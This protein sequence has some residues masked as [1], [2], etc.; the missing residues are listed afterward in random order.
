VSAEERSL[1]EIRKALAGITRRLDALADAVGVA[2]ATAPPGALLDEATRSHLA[3]LQSVLAVGRGTTLFETCI[4]GIDRALSQARADCAAILQRTGDRALTVLAQRGFRLPLEPDAGAGIVGRALD[5]SEVVQAGPGLGGP[6]ALL[7]HHGLGAAVAVPIR[8]DT[9]LANGVLLVGR[10]R[11]VPFEA[12]AVG[13]LL[14]VADR[15]PGA[16]RPGPGTQRDQTSTLTLFTSLDPSRTAATVASEAK[17]QLGAEAV[18]VLVP[19][20]DGF[21]LAGSAGLGDDIPPLSRAPALHEVATTGRAWVSTPGAPDDSELAGWLGRAPRAVLPL[22]ANDQVVA[23]LAIAGSC[24]TAL[25]PAFARAAALAL[26]NARLHGESLRALAQPAPSAAG[27]SDASHA[28]L[29]DMASLLAIVLARLAAARERVADTATTRDLADAEEAAWRVAEAVRRVLGFVPASGT[30]SSPPVDLAALV[31]DATEASEA[32]WA[33][34]GRAPAIA[35]DLDAAPPVRV[36]P[37]EFRQALR[38]LL[39]NAREATADGRGGV[40]AVR[41]RWDGGSRVEVSVTDEG[42]GMDDTTRARAGEPFFTTKGSGRL[43]VGL[44]VVQ[45]MAQRHRGGMELTTSPGQGTT[46]RL[47]FPTASDPQPPP[48]ASRSARPRRRIL[49]VDDEKAIR[50]TLTQALEHDG[51]EVDATGDVGDAVALLGRIRVDLVVTDLVLPGGSG[52][53]VARTVKRVHPDAPVILITGWPGRVDPETLEGQGIDAIVEKP[54][55]LDT[56]RSAVRALIQ[57]GVPRAR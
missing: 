7:E 29:G 52:L 53:E 46:V 4:L 50:E 25:T 40:I 9:G 34:D 41:L 30:S 38:H 57:R 32:L 10:R 54:V 51:Y 15:L 36:H 39:D 1:G 20:G 23:L 28:P 35:L 5:A 27:Q 21:A 8:D 24:S 16:I 11:P 56:L 44:A 22:A 55:G 31:R 33:Q 26:R 45:A 2:A 48:A 18:A 37:D 13:T 17:T 49:V 43:G 42:H 12:D 6:D 19:D 14:M 3:G 47:R